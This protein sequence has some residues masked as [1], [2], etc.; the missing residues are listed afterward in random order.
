MHLAVVVLRL[1]K[2]LDYSQVLGDDFNKM[3][4]EIPKPL[5]PTDS[6]PD[7]QTNYNEKIHG[8]IDSLSRNV[9]QGKIYYQ[10]NFTVR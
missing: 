10:I 4:L 5:Q 9:S 2:G 8:S 3:N 1:E 7:F 6:T